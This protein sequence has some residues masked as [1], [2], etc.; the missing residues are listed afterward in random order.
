MSVVQE[1]LPV[2]TAKATRMHLEVVPQLLLLQPYSSSNVD[3]RLPALLK[4]AQQFVPEAS[5]PN[6]TAHGQ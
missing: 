5:A 2:Y 4:D 6:R 3:L 1:L